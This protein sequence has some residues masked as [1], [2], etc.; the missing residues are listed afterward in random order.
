M[1]LHAG[2]SLHLLR[3]GYSFVLCLAA[4][5]L[6]HVPNVAGTV[7]ATACPV[8]LGA[9]GLR[10][11]GHR[12]VLLAPH[13]VLTTGGFGDQCGRHCRL[14][15]L[16]VLRKRGDIWRSST[17]NVAKSGKAWGKLRMRV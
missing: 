16:H 6:W 12:S 10:R 2:M 7:T 9:S 8:D 17:V 11:Y 5:P 1:G 4:F 13:V 15:D 14:T 3:Q